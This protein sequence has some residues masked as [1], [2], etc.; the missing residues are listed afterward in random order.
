MTVFYP[1]ATNSLLPLVL[2][3][4]APLNISDVNDFYDT[5]R[6][7][8]HTG[9]FNWV[10]GAK[11]AY[12]VSPTYVFSALHD[13]LADIPILK[14]IDSALITNRSVNAF[15]W[16]CSVAIEFFEVEPILSLEQAYAVVFTEGNAEN[17]PLICYFS[18]VLELP[19]T[20]DGRSW[21]LYPNASQAGDV[22]G[23]GGWFA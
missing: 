9:L 7:R 19:F 1:Y 20:P 14:R 4:Q 17:S 11:Y 2:E 23:S 18:E 13:T 10:T 16:C 3:G 8:R 21:Y 22:T 5:C 12:L 6:V 15:G